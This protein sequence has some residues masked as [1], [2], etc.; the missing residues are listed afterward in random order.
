MRTRPRPRRTIAWTAA[1]VLIVAGLLALGVSIWVAMRP[2][3]NPGVQDCGPALRFLLSNTENVVLHPGEPGSPPDALALAQQPTCRDLAIVQVQK[4]GLA[5]AAFAGFLLAGIVVGLVDDR[6]GYWR[7]PRF[8]SLLRPMP[9]EA[10]VAHGLEPNVDA[11]EL[12]V[13]LPPVEPNEVVGLAIGGVVSFAGLVLLAGGGGVRAAF[14]GASGSLLALAV[15]LAL[16]SFVCAAVQRRPVYPSDDSWV[17]LVELVMAASWIGRLRPFV[18]S[19]GIDL[20]HLRK[21]GVDLDDATAEVE[22]LQ[23]ASA[24][25]HTV[26]LAVAAALALRAPRPEV[27]FT[28]RDGALAAVALLLVLNGLP[29]LRRRLRGLPVAPGRAGVRRLVALRRQ[30]GRLVTLLSATVALELTGAGVVAASVAAFG[31]SV[32]F[33]SVV[34]VVLGAATLGALG[35]THHGVVVFEAAATLGLVALGVALPIAVAATLT[36]RTLTSWVPMAAGWR[37][38]RRMQRVGAI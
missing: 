24:L 35:S 30:P 17:R 5:A 27:A 13:A 15:L 11:D 9:R 38:S 16:G 25:C 23:T 10:R 8:E 21:A 33:V 36:S 37:A 32:P 1:K 31:G 19:F 2:V 22:L 6:V 3:A 18:G 12:G 29:R 26:V 4:A 14:D 34:A 28:A 20:H 7:A